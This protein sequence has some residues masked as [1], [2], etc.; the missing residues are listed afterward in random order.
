VTFEPNKEYVRQILAEQ[1]D[2]RTDGYDYVPVDDLPSDHRFFRFQE[3]MNGDGVP[4]EQVV[5]A[6]RESRGT[7]YR[8][9]TDGPNPIDELRPV[10]AGA[11]EER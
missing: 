5:E 11:R 8:D 9:E 6:D 3:T 1:Y 10:G 4:S 7:E 2:L